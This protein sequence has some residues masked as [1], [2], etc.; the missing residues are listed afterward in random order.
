MTMLELY[1]P[2][3]AFDALEAFLA[4]ELREGLVADVFLAYGLAE[5]LPIRVP[6]GS[7]HQKA[8]ERSG[9]ITRGRT[10]EWVKLAGTSEP[11]VS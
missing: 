11:S 2:A 4:E 7:K 9:L 10:A 6:G 5:P 3:G 1:E 8:L